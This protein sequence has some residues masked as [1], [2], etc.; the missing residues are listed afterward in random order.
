MLEPALME[1]TADALL[2][3]IVEEGMPL[4]KVREKTWLFFVVF[5]QRKTCLRKITHLF[6]IFF[7]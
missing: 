4:D 3:V 6:S 7:F 5:V 2:G 1:Q